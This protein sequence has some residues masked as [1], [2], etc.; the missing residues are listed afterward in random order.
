MPDKIKKL[1][2]PEIKEI[3]GEYDTESTFEKV[4][5]IPDSDELYEKLKEYIDVK[6]F[7][8][9]A[10]LGIDIYRYGLYPHLEQTLIPTVFK[11]FF[12]KAMRLCLE[13][14]QFVFQNYS[15]EKIEKS[16]ISTG[17]GGFVIFD[18]P[19]HALF[20]AINFEILVRSFNAYH[21]YPKLRNI[22]GGV[23]L[24]YAITYDTLFSFDNNF[25]GTSII[26]NARIL[27]KDALNRCLIDQ[28][29]YNW[30]LINIDGIENLQVLTIHELANIAEFQDYDKEIIRTGENEIIDTKM[31]RDWGV[32]N[33]DVLKIGQIRSKE[34]DLNIYNIHLQVTVKVF[35]DRN[36]DI[37]RTLTMSLGNLNTSGI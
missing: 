9:R 20:F 17:D 22:T 5:V 11:I 15:K 31:S 35:A 6:N 13:N 21:V 27:E 19:M 23:S 25:Y 1:S 12:E 26:N 4:N 30:F 34:L 8:R 2:Y 14:N 7:K 18:T 16:F 29:T 28:N 36:K 37:K 3:L 24:R 10:V 33:S 32:I